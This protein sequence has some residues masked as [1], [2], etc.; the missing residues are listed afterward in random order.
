MVPSVE[1]WQELASF[2]I[3]LNLFTM[4]RLSTLAILAVLLS[5][6]A[7]ATTWTVSNNLNKPAQF[8]SLQTAIDAAAIGD[9]LLIS[10]SPNSYGNIT[11]SKQL[12]LIGEGIGSS[13]DHPTTLGGFY[14]RCQNGTINASGSFLEG[15]IMSYLYWGG[16]NYSSDADTLQNVTIN[17]CRMSYV[18]RAIYGNGTVKGFMFNQCIIDHY[19]NFDGT[20]GWLGNLTGTMEDVDFAN[21]VFNGLSSYHMSN[22]GD[23]NGQL[24]M[25]N[26]LFL[27]TSQTLNSGNLSEAVFEDCMFIGTNFPTNL[28]GCVFNHCLSHQGDDPTLPPAGNSGSGNVS[29]ADPLFTAYNPTPVNHS[30]AH[31]YTLQAGSPAIGAGTSGTDIG[32]G[33]GAVSSFDGN[34]PQTPRGPV[35]TS[36]NLPVTAVAVGGTL[37]INVSAE[38]RD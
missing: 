37:Q 22:V 8:T 30:W 32:M 11:L 36:L 6:N 27:S 5:F 9:T 12:H 31:D 10:G 1:F 18:Q 33:G 17:R 4:L 25:R 26:C 14:M 3:E 2:K 20:N 34:L 21:C 28:S 13:L 23:C 24:V 29:D 7:S 19:V 38:S 15:L 35:V 16:G